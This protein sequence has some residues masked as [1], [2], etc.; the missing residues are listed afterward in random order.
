MAFTKET[1]FTAIME[2]TRKVY[3]IYVVTNTINHKLYIGMTNNFPRRCREHILA[4]KRPKPVQ[5]IHRAIAKYGEKHFVFELLERKL[6]MREAMQK[7]L[8]LVALYNAKDKRFGYNGRKGGDLVH[9]R[10]SGENHPL[11]QSK[12]LFGC[13]DISVELSKRWKSGIYDSNKRKVKGT[14]REG[15]IFLFNSAKEAAEQFKVDSSNITRACQIPNRIT[16]GLTW[17][18]MSES[19]KKVA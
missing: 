14:D 18:Y 19:N 10:L 16:A 15:N 6:T 8:R 3:S 17:E 13:E 5:A 11:Y 12:A 1:N 7:E 9:P 2:C 4:S